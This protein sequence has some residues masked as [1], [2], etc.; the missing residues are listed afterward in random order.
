MFQPLGQPGHDRGSVHEIVVD[1]RDGD[2]DG[3]LG[4][5]FCCR[6]RVEQLDPEVSPRCVPSARLDLFF[7]L[8]QIVVNLFVAGLRF[9]DLDV[10]RERRR[11]RS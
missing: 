4:T 11:V 9:I 7:M 10:G 3:E 6:W 1:R 2:Q 5:G 8:W